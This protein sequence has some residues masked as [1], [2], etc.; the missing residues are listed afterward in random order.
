[1]IENLALDTVAG[2]LPGLIGQIDL[3]G[4][5]LFASRAYSD[6]YGVPLDRIIGNTEE[7]LTTGV[8]QWC[9]E[10][11]SCRIRVLGQ[12]DAP[13][14]HDER[15]RDRRPARPRGLGR[16]RRLQP[17]RRAHSHRLI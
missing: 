11:P 15:R 8:P 13:V 14:G 10:K 4:R 12:H 1:M 9:P 2:Q 16:A 5:Y 3:E 17:R 6:W 7:E